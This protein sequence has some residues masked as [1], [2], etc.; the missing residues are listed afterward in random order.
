MKRLM[1]AIVALALVL[2]GCGASDA[3]LQAAYDDGFAAAQ[4]TTV[5]PETHRCADEFSETFD[6]YS[7][8]ECVLPADEPVMPKDEATEFLRSTWANYADRPLGVAIVDSQSDLAKRNARVPCS[9]ACYWVGS[10]GHPNIYISPSHATK[11]TIL[12]E[13]AHGL[14]G[15]DGH[16]ETFRC[17]ALSLYAKHGAAEEVEQLLETC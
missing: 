9:S 17:T 14:H 5:V 8:E 11:S 2:A 7:W 13:I 1:I 4:A 10:T 16:G 15:S 6:A 3:D 12:H